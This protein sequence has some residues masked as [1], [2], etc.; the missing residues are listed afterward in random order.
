M[1]HPHDPG[2]RDEET[3]ALIDL[4]VLSQMA[5]A[6]PPRG[7]ASASSLALPRFAA[8]DLTG[9]AT[10]RR[11]PPPPPPPRPRNVLAPV[12]EPR[13]PL[14]A[15][16]ASLTVAV[17]ALATYVIVR[18]APTVV[19]QAPATSAAPSVIAADARVDR[20]SAAAVAASDDDDDD[21][22][23]DEDEVAPHDEATPSVELATP[24]PRDRTRRHTDRDRAPK[25]DPRTTKVTPEAAPKTSGPSLECQLGIGECTST[26]TPRKPPE[27][28]DPK[29][30][31]P[32]RPAKLTTVQVR[33]AIAGPKRSAK[34]CGRTHGAAAGD[35]VEVKLSI[36]G[37]TG[38]VTSATPV[39]EHARSALGRCVAD[40]LAK[41]S[42]P[43]FG[44]P[45]MGV[46][47][48]VRM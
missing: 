2:R 37:A 27:D 19:V 30:T 44:D 36:A 5:Q 31:D 21:E 25:S 45:A 47:F 41:A 7:S 26:S 11:T 23:Q 4:R 38:K 17:A 32:S 10:V 33:N 24:S 9:V 35:R 48:G 15:L 42:F 6:P 22:P 43:K 13:G 18:P 12:E 1:P 46:S 14:Y 29:T 16:L 8:T 39:G 20:S 40:A 34:Q 28:P 3:S